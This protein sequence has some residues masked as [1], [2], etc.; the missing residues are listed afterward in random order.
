MRLTTDISSWTASKL[1]ENDLISLKEHIH[2]LILSLLWPD[3][4]ESDPAT[5]LASRS[6]GTSKTIDK[7][8]YAPRIPLHLE[9]SAMLSNALGS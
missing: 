9:H 1:E 4:Y 3:E 6:D 7:Q 5:Q 8:N 2:T